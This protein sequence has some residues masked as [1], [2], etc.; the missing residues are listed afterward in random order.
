MAL[1]KIDVANMLTGA[2]PMA[3][4][5]TA[6]TSGFSNGITMANNWRVTSDFTDD[7]DPISAN[8]EQADTDGYGKLGGDMAVSSGIWTFPS[9]GVYLLQFE[10][11]VTAD[12]IDGLISMFIDTTTDN[13]NYSS[14]S[15]K[16]FGV[17]RASDRQMCSTQAI[18][19]VT[20]TTTHK[21]RFHLTNASSD[22]TTHGNTSKNETAMTF[23]RLGDT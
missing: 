15:V 23:I 4:G 11:Y 7:A 14:I 12:N 1:S 2:T 16:E 6:L 3:N 18:F 5:G 22:T 20:N 9:T 13:S 17:S 10:V 8:L 21:C 19:D